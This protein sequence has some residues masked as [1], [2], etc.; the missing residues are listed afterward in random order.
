MKKLFLTLVLVLTVSFAF[1]TDEENSKNSKENSDISYTYILNNINDI[2]GACWATFTM[3]A[4]NT[5]T[6]EVRQTSIRMYLGE[7]YSMGDCRYLAAQ[8]ALAMQ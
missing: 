5:N 8:T 7:T 6:G 1:A 4:T 2:P 3:T